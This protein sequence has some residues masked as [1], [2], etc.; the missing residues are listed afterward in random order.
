MTTVFTS[1]LGATQT[2]IS[3]IDFDLAKNV[4]QVHGVDAQSKAVVRT[5]L[6][7][8]QLPPFKQIA[9]MQVRH[10]QAPMH[11]Q[12]AEFIALDQPAGLGGR[13][14]DQLRVDPL[15]SLCAAP[16]SCTARASP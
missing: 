13:A 5:T 9:E 10:D 3:A 14:H 8:A 11:T 4:F 2:E 1:K 16:R 12:G 15:C 6:R 7:R